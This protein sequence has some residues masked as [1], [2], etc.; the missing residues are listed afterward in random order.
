MEG[1]DWKRI[2]R[3]S[4]YGREDM[5]TRLLDQVRQTC[6]LRHL[7]RRTEEAYAGWIRRYVVY[8]G[9]RHPKEMGPDEV[10]AFLTHLATDDKVAASTQNQAGRAPLPV[11]RRPSGRAAPRRRR[12]EGEETQATPGRPHPLGGSA[13]HGAVGGNARGGGGPAVWFGY[14]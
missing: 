12:G 9:K 13:R 4:A 10:R 11:P 8:H 1:G 7:S 6:R 5:G 14:P 3:Y 2:A